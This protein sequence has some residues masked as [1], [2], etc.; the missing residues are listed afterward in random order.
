MSDAE[1]LP[2]KERSDRAYCLYYHEELDLT[3]SVLCLRVSHAVDAI[4]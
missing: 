1:V 2:S 4:A 3:P